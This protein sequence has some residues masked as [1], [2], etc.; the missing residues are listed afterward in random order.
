MTVKFITQPVPM[1]YLNGEEVNEEDAANIL[2]GGVY[3]SEIVNFCPVTWVFVI[4]IDDQLILVDG[5]DINEDSITE[6]IYPEETQ[7]YK[8]AQEELQATLTKR[9]IRIAELEDK[10]AKPFAGQNLTINKAYKDGWE[11]CAKT[12]MSEAAEVITVLSN[13]R[14]RA[15]QSFLKNERK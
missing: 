11:D 14:N 9:D 13:L 15:Y 4:D 10:L 8:D 5:R 12:T 2:G 6:F 7:D 3:P 1:H